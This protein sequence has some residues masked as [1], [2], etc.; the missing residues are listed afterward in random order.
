MDHV[1]GWHSSLSPLFI[2]DAAAHNHP[3]ILSYFLAHE[4][5]AAAV[6]PA[7][8][9]NAMLAAADTNAVETLATLCNFFENHPEFPSYAGQAYRVAAHQGS[10]DALTLLSSY[11]P[12]SMRYKAIPYAV[13]GG[14]AT[15]VRTLLASMS[16]PGTDL[17]RAALVTAA[18]AG[19]WEV[20][21]DLLVFPNTDHLKGC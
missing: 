3:A 6:K 4:A 7:H 5:T 14:Q 11:I 15:L 10:A 18:H 20:L 12:A 2:I 17:H 8:I 16:K 1:L 13:K 21:E 19:Q 9:G